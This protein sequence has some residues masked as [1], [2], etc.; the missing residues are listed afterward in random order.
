[1]ARTSNLWKLSTDGTYI[2]TIGPSGYDLLINGS[3][4]YINF[5]TT[6]GV[7]GYGI[8]DN[9]GTIQWKN[10]G[11]VWANIGSG[12]GGGSVTL[13]TNGVT[14]GSQTLLNLVQGTGM[15]ITDD[16]SGN[17]TFASSGGGGAVSSVFGRTGIIIAVSGDYTT[18]QVTESGNLYFT[19]ARAIASTLTSYASGAG[20]ISAT[21]SV[22]SAIQKLNGNIVALGTPVTSVS[23][24]TNRITSTGGT[25]PVI[26][27]STTFEALLGKIATGLQQ[28][29]STTSAQL[30]GVISDETGSGALVFGTNPTISL[31]TASTATTQ[32]PADNSTKIATTAYVD[33]AILGQRYKEAAKY[34]T[35]AALPTVVYNNG[36]SGVGATLTASS[37]GAISLDGSTPSIGDRILVKNQVSTFQNG[38]Y[39]VTVVGTVGTVFV[40]TRATDFNQASEIQTGDS[41]FVTSGTSL[42]T[43]TWAYTGIDSPTMGTTALTWAQAAGQGSFTSG[44]GILIT[45]VSIAIDTSVTVDKTTAQ[46]L[47]NKTFVAPALGTPASG[48]ATNLTGLPISTGV[49]G[50]GT[51]IATFLTT[52]SSANLAAAVTDETGTAGFLVFSVSPAFTG[53]PTA[54][55]ATV[56]TNTTQ[57][58]TTAFVL[59]NAGGGG[60]TGANPTASVGLTAV[61]GSATTFLR[62]DGAPAL[63]QAIVP[64]WTG[65]HTFTPAARTSGVASYFT[66]NTP[67]DTGIT[68]NTQSIGINIP[69]GTRTWADGTVASQAE[70]FFGA[71]TYNKTTTAA[72][73]TMAGTLVIGGAPNPGTGVTIANPYNIWVQGT[74]SSHFG[75]QLGGSP[76]ALVSGTGIEIVDSNNT[77]GG[78][79]LNVTNVSGGANAFTQVNLN[80]DTAA[81]STFTFY[82][83]MYLNS[84]GYTNIAFGTALSTPN[85]LALQNATG[86]PI[87]IGTSATGSTNGKINFLIGGF[88]T[89]NEVGEWNAAGLSVGLAGT[90][91]GAIALQ[92]ST[93]GAAT[94]KSPAIVSTYSL[95]VPGAAPTSPGQGITYDGSAVGSF[96]K[97]PIT[98]YCGAPGTALTGT[99][100]LTNLLSV[101]IPAGLIQAGANIKIFAS[102][103]GTGTSGTKTT[104]IAYDTVNAGTAG[105]AF[106]SVSNTA[107]AGASV[108]A[109]KEILFLTTSSQAAN[110]ALLQAGLGASTLPAVT[111][112]L[113]TATTTTYINFISQLGNAGD[114]VTLVGVNIILMQ[115]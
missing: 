61:N 101:P 62:S 40:L 13:A 102:W 111:S 104:T 75:P 19:N 30:A 105:T 78:H 63:S 83:G 23:G 1:M 106:F 76:N 100:A 37:V 97:M 91:S 81:G 18:A 68:A 56:G 113:N 47:S 11:G 32:T 24:T 17:I 50:L 114:T 27:I 31:N 6:V 93:S 29:A 36:S 85:Q 15:T 108:P 58:A 84:N 109:V 96:T 7:N 73:F 2:Q 26:D 79:G 65:V 99:T 3:N 8:R 39:L 64:T 45:G 54:P 92:G 87:T 33:A 88:N 59:A 49:S 41:V 10:S 22:L 69:G 57:I 86:G 28:F 9:G 71:P 90:L 82:A 67:S 20:T 4:H 48:V 80:N 55:T 72:T 94:I 53:T 95:T 42:S 110:S 25:T 52:P 103:K 14:N 43:T 34:A 51:G 74:G 35:T 46:T 21:D 70:Y 115:P 12:G 77:T 44:N 60:G 16:G 107:T 89:A 112:S 98:L 5:G 66:I 38:I